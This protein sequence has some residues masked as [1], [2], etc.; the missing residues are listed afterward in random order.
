VARPAELGPLEITITPPPGLRPDDV[1][2]YAD[3][4]VDRLTL[5]ILARDGKE[6]VGRVERAADAFLGK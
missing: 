5:L 4:G 2:R 3:L 6:L 1:A